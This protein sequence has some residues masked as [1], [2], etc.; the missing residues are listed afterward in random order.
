ML[1]ISGSPGNVSSASAWPATK[2][3][4]AK[5]SKLEIYARVIDPLSRDPLSD[6][7][8]DYQRRACDHRQEWRQ[9]DR[10]LTIACENAGAR[11]DTDAQ[12]DRG[13]PGPLK[14]IHMRV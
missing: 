7:P 2:I 10:V 9:M 1:S 14:C 5:L 4:A 3:A 11:A 6:P 8:A 12:A 13:P